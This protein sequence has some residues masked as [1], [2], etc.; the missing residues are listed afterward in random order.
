[1]NIGIFMYEAFHLK[2]RLDFTLSDALL[3]LFLH[4]LEKPWKLSQSE[5]AMDEFLKHKEDKA[6]LEAKTAEYGFELTENH[7]NALKYVHGEGK[8]FNPH[9]R[10]QKPLAAFV[11]LC[12]T[13]SARIWFDYPKTGGSW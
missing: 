9:T 5:T 10:V 1:M 2:R 13:A 8:D 12:D 11:H 3:V 7:W 4:D 6:F